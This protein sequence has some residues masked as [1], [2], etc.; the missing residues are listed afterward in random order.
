M[1]MGR[2]HCNKVD[3]LD[4]KVKR[5]RKYIFFEETHSL[6]IFIKLGYERKML[7][8]TYTLVFSIV[9]IIVCTCS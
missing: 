4:T 3:K 7:L 5:K 1:G 6:Y 9:Y 8:I 2:S